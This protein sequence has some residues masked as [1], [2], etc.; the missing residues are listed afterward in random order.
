MGLKNGS[1]EYWEIKEHAERLYRKRANAS[2]SSE[3]EMYIE[4]CNEYADRL[5]EK[6]GFD[7]EVKYIIKQYLK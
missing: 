5:I 6:Y 4:K 1:E 2:S 7:K 3:R